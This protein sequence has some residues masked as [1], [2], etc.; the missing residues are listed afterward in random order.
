MDLLNG[1]YHEN[2]P[3][4]LTISRAMLKSKDLPQEAGDL[5]AKIYHRDSDDD[6]SFAARLRSLPRHWGSLE[7]L[8]YYDAMVNNGG[9]KQY[10]TNSS[11][12]YLDMV[13]SGLALYCDQNIQ[14]IF[15]RALFRYDA[16]RFRDYG[17]LDESA[18]GLDGRS[19]SPYDDLDS[20]YFRSDPSLT[21]QVDKY[22][23]SN[24]DA[25][26]E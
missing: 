2:L 19:I 12:A 24:L 14:N 5:V 7:C 26:E 25:F 18:G 3:D 6:F 10:F 13:E 17:F 20:L 4:R 1:I 11:G 22:I 16:V 15:K 9:H 8:M 21:A 23:R